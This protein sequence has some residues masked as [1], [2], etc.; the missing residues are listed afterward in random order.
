MSR[1]TFVFFLLS[2][3][4]LAQDYRAT[5]TGT[6]TDPSGATVAGAAVRATSKVNNRGV[7]VKTTADGVYTIPYLEPG[8]Y[9]VDVTAPGF[10]NV[11]LTA[12]ELQTQQRLNLPVRMTLGEAK[13]QVT[14]EA[15]QELIDSTD[16]NRGLVFD[17]LK[18]Q[19]MPLNGRQAYM[20]L[21]L[22]PGVIFTQEQ[23][24]AAGFSGTRG[25]DVNS[26]FKFNG[27][28]SGNGN[29]IFLM[30][31]SPVSN[32]GSTWE[33]SPTIDSIQEFKAITTAF[34]AQYGHE[35]GGIV[36][37]TIKSGTNHWHGDA[38]DY[39]RN[40][41]LDANSFQNNVAGMGKGRHNQ[42]QFGGVI[43]GPIRKNKDFLFAGYEGWQEVVPFPAQ[44]TTVP[45]DLRNGQNFSNYGISIFDPLTT[46]ACGASNE[47]CSQ[48]PYWR[49]AF[50]GDV[51][52]A[53]RISPVGQK[54]LSYLPPPNSPGQGAGGITNNFVANTNEGRYWYNQP[55]VRWDHV[56]N[57]KDKFTAMYTNFHGFEYRS[58]IGFANPVA[59]GNMD[60]ERTFN[61]IN[62][63]ETH[64]L[65]PTAVLD[66]RGNFM[67]FTQLSPGYNNQA[68]D[69]TAQSIG[70]TD[71]IH[72]PTVANGVIPNINITGIANNSSTT[73][74]ALFGSGSYSWSPY[75]SWDLTPNVT[76]VRGT[77]TL[78]MGFEYRYEA[79]GN[80]S[81]GNAYG[82]F[83][84]NSNFTRQASGRSLVATDAF[85]SIASV[86]LGIP[87]SGN[88][89]NNATSYNTRQYY[90]GYLQDDWKVNSRLA[91]N[92]GL[93]YE[94]QLPYLERYNRMD[95]LFN[96]NVTNPLNDQVLSAWNAAKKT[97]DANPANKYPYPA[98][99]AAILGGYQFAGQNGLPRRQ[100]Y[101][102]WTTLAPRFGF[103]YRAGDKTAIRGGV[104]VF[105]QS[106]TQTGAPQTG[107]SAS[108]PYLNSLDGG[109]TPSA[110]ANGG[111]AGSTP[112]GPYSLVDPF[113]NGLQASPGSSLGYLTNVGNTVGSINNLTYKIPRTYQYSLGIQRQ[114]P[115]D[116]VID[117]AFGGNFAGNTPYSMDMNWPQD[118]A[119]VALYQQAIADPNFFS[120]QLANPFLGIVPATSGLGSAK[121][122]SADKLMGNFPLWNGSSA[123]NS[124]VQNANIARGT[125]R[126]DAGQLRF[127]KRAFGK[128]EKSFGLVTWVLAYTFSKQYALLC[129]ATGYSWM[130][131]DK[132][133][134]YQL[135]SNNK[136]Q[137]VNLHGIW[138]LPF[139]KG[140]RFG[141]N[142][143]GAPGKL[144]SGWRVDYILSYISGFPVGLP[145][146]INSCGQWENGDAQNQY[147]W[148][149][150]NP[151]CYAQFPAN[152]GGFS[153][154]PPRFSGNVNNPAKP[155]LNLAIEKNTSLG[156]RYTLKFRAES[157][158]LTNTPI[159]PGPS[160]TF[161]GTTFGVLPASQQNFPRLV[162]LALKLDF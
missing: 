97:Y 157:F 151:S 129:C 117:V 42:N 5:L 66:V 95:S 35:A 72:A 50:P 22:T 69:I 140:Q 144:A 31:G 103:A 51:I 146:L 137:E 143:H 13:A 70:M 44:G 1:N 34:D 93:R 60:N 18:T 98:P 48:S 155:Q 150:N 149:N 108:T 45:M 87:D 123:N 135:D 132:S 160:T 6:V 29:N 14:V 126:S 161:P 75:T 74:N 147:H 96:V 16:S 85:D 63:D 125:F 122:I 23:F 86:L 89:D 127:E 9:D 43:G 53:T 100:F 76:W 159:R 148:F 92:L 112:S 84:F 124:T 114:L 52:P 152:A 36:N 71:M 90:A 121:T 56:F 99:P 139:G 110:C 17:P 115:W 80:V 61:G 91:L 11:K 81:L 10:R 41:V 30:N 138:D 38:Y 57:D 154:L 131:G 28:R 40:R 64:V 2:I 109:I 118:A 102:D 133:M 111:C 49:T 83:T 145:N 130:T 67:R 25:W 134:R 113:P 105:Y 119:G 153:Y 55:I 4:I 73:S 156:E 54:I 7:S 116:M 142:V 106:M 32:E 94:V 141:A 136:T 62:L 20:L 104:G 107:F 77:H 19:E 33:F 21:T 47:S 101:P 12:V 27:A 8:V 15:R 79:R 82:S 58:T 65:S 162:Q 24:G 78:H 39:L 37:T 128:S 3:G 46:H 26:S 68:L 88:I 120:R 158:N 59:T